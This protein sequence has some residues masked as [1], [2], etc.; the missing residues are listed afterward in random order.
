MSAE[1]KLTKHETPAQA[2]RRAMLMKRVW[3]HACITVL[4][5]MGVYDQTVPIQQQADHFL[6]DGSFA[7]AVK[8]QA[9]I[10]ARQYGFFAFDPGLV[11]SALVI[12]GKEMK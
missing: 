8:S 9:D 5:H 7:M 4:R 10:Y 11:E 3:R 12:R 2:H 6:M 1:P